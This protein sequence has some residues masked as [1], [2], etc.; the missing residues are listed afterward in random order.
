MR[1]VPRVVPPVRRLPV[2]VLFLASAV[3]V[4][5]CGGGPP[6]DLFVVERAGSLPA[7][8]LTL[9]VTDDAGAYCNRQDR[10]EIT[11][12]QLIEARALRRELNG[13][14]EQHPGPADRGT[15]LPALPGSV[16]RYRV[17]TEDGTVAFAD[18]SRGSPTAFSRMIKLTRDI[19]RGSC[20]LPR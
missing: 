8:R 14:D 12:A 6:A 4:T 20:R 9:R 7:A 1:A 10:R 17:V 11:S 16:L 5:A 15:R 19:A 3:A 18:N 2:L 13:A